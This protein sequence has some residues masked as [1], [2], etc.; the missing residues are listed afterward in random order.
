[1]SKIWFVA[2][3]LLTVVVGACEDILEVPDISNQSV[4]ILAPMEQAALT[5]SLVT[6]SWEDLEEAEAYQVQLATP[7]FE[8]AAQI[9]LDSTIVLDTTFLGTQVYKTLNNGAY[10]WRVRALNSN[11]STPFSGASF[12][13]TLSEN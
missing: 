7:D 1:M 9:L 12:T 8:N 2:L 11:Y 6:L 4:A 10:Q 5:D 3:L 13:V